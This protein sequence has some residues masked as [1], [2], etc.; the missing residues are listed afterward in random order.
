M[1]MNKI[2][3]FKSLMKN[4]KKNNNKYNNFQEL[5]NNNIIKYKVN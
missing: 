3:N 5:N 4:Y 2:K 1:S